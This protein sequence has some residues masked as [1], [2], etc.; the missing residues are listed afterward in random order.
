VKHPE[1]AAEGEL[2]N[3][4]FWL[5]A[6]SAKTSSAFSIVKARTEWSLIEALA[7]WLGD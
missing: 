4:A 2:E 5:V 3:Y 6:C 7:E 1:I